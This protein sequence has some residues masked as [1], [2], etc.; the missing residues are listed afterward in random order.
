MIES[1]RFSLSF[2]LITSALLGTVFGQGGDQ[3][4]GEREQKLI[5]VLK[6]DAAP[7]DKAMAC[8]QLAVYGTKEAVATLSP[9]LSNEELAS[10]ARIALEAIPDAACD[11]ALREA[12]GRLKGR[13]A[14]GAINSLGVRR[15]AGAVS[16][17]AGRL[18]DGDVDLIEAAA[19]ALGRIGTMQAGDI[20]GR[21]L[22][23]SSARD[24]AGIA[25]GCVLCAERFLEQDKTAEATKLYDAV[26][27]ADV[28]VQTVLEATRGSVLA[29]GAAGTGLLISLLKSDDR[30]QLGI[31]LR[32][33]RELA[34][35][36]VTE[37]LAAELGRLSPDRQRLLLMAISDRSDAAVLPTLTKAAQPG[38][39]PQ[40]R[41][42]A[43]SILEH[44][45]DVSSIPVLLEAAA[46]DDAALSAQAR[47][48]LS[49]LG[50][51]DVDNALLA[52]LP[53]AKGRMLQALIELAG[54]RQ[55]GGA[56]AAVL[57]STQDADAGVRGAAVKTVG[58]LG[59]TAEAGTLVRLLM[60]SQSGEERAGIERALRNVSGRSRAACTEHVLPLMKS[61]DGALRVI[62]LRVLAIAGGPEALGAVVSA[63][64][65]SNEAVQDEAIRTLSTWPNTWPNDAA[66]APPLLELA[67][68]GTKQ[69]HRVLGKRGYLQ[70]VRS[71]KDLTGAQ[72]LACVAEVLPL[73]ER[74]EEK[75]L[76]IAALGEIRVAGSV[77]AL[78]ELAEDAAIGEEAW[79]AIAGL[80]QTN[81][82][83]VSVEQRRKLLETVIEKSGN[84]ATR[85]KAA[86]ALKQVR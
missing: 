52:R 35:Q 2:V 21:A 69:S 27:A 16:V 23:S 72:K 62:G 59:G 76:A 71:T 44:S 80:A 36:D 38:N 85:R 86:A 40:L 14:I 24:R 48:S 34:G 75:R 84:E 68:S 58:E 45:G 8:K 70:Y 10:W 54:D 41:M 50:G 12:A 66:V 25:H 55:I 3:P 9:L 60:H 22:A 39:A 81:I 79:L 51:E 46:G 18:K 26:R 32:T 78:T 29:R 28:P 42:T 53:Q 31:G 49:R 1:G 64:K 56:L 17:L 33:A 61:Q 47:I 37:A 65:D 6:S 43:V 15:D 20:L 13:L 67:K 77:Q 19:A 30:Q 11:A 63:T 4:G 5:A 83:G 82:E 57:R 7:A 73:A 74:P